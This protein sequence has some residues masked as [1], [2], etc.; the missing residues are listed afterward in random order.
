MLHLIGSNHGYNTLVECCGKVCEGL[1]ID[2]L[3][4]AQS[5]VGKGFIP[6]NFMEEVRTLAGTNLEK[7]TKLYEALLK[8]VEHNPNRYSDFMS[9]LE[10]NKALH[11]DL[12]TALRNTHLKICKNIILSFCKN[13][14]ALIPGC[15]KTHFIR[16]GTEASKLSLHYNY[17]ISSL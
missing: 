17:Y 14:I 16:P 5:L 2:L 1:S 3:N 11:S 6:A 10:E 15:I 13:I 8:V 12:L 7:G 4:I 9:V